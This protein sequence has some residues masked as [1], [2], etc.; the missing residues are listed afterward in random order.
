MIDS[1][2]PQIIDILSSSSDS[3][4]VVEVI[5][6]RI[7]FLNLSFLSAIIFNFTYGKL[8]ATS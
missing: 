3:S 1:K 7:S 8:G 4:H 2:T 5:H 6:K